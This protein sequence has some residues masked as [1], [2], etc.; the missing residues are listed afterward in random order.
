MTVLKTTA[1]NGVNLEWLKYDKNLGKWPLEPAA[2][3]R[4]A[5]VKASPLAAPKVEQA[6]PTGTNQAI[7]PNTFA[8]KVVAT[9]LNFYFKLI[10]HKF[11]S[12][13]LSN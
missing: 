4:R 5:E 7:L 12:D 9:A 6:T 3:A 8:P 13:K 1:I 10:G 2:Y 11:F